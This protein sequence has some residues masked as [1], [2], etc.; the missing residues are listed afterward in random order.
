MASIIVEVS[1]FL[2]QESP[3]NVFWHEKIFVSERDAFARSLSLVT[4]KR[5]YPLVIC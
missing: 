1:S 5:A 4:A 2:H 3:K